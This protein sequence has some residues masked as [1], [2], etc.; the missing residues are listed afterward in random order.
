MSSNLIKLSD[1][2]HTCAM[3][4]SM[5]RFRMTNTVQ[6]HVDE[7][8]KKGYCVLPGQFPRPA[9]DECNKAFPPM[10]DDLMARI[11]EGNR[12][13][14]CW[15]IR[16]PFAPPFITR[17]FSTMSQWFRSSTHPWGRIR[18]LP[19]MPSTYRS[20]DRHISM[21]T[22]MGLLCSWN[23]RVINIHQ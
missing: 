23:C 16:L 18:T 17:P 3:G 15:A 7:I 22:A 6:Q 14:N 5:W 10:L 1:H 4:T 20:K 12:R 19:L 13:T 9:L 2:F 21:F 8:M 11:P